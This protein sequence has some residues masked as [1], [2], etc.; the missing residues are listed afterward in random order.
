MTRDLEKALAGLAPVD[1]TAA[2]ERFLERAQAEG[3]VD[4]AY[5]AV[6]SPL[7]ELVAAV[8]PK[9]LVR[10][11]YEDG[12]F[13]SVLTEL[14]DRVSPR[15]IEAPAR[16]DDV[17][18][19]LDEYFEGRRQGFDLPVDWTLTH[20]FTRRVLQSTGEDLLRR[21]R[22]LSRGGDRRRQRGR[23]AR[24]RQRAGRQP[25][26]D[27]RPLP[28]H[29]AHRR[30]PRRLYRRDRTQAVPAQ[31]GRGPEALSP[32]SSSAGEDG[33]WLAMPQVLPGR[34]NCVATNASQ[35]RSGRTACNVSGTRAEAV[36]G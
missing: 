13:D 2:Q 22:H 25:D 8:T 29:R 32:G 16:L 11:A 33:A 26:A 21:P 35:P 24:G 18:R 34:G 5:T 4:V 19:Q 17:R 36:I 3:L 6:D 14:A 10:L 15:V 20:G 1:A 23:G 12:R 31:A 27:R 30:R 7:G 28:P 9:G